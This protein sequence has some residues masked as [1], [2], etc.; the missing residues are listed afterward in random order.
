MWFKGVELS[1]E[2]ILVIGS[3]LDCT[4]AMIEHTF[5]QAYNDA[6]KRA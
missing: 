4:R 3:A 6:F 5:D 1:K 2:G